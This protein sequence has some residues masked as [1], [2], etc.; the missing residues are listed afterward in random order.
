MTRQ[1]RAFMMTSVM[2]AAIIIACAAVDVDSGLHAKQKEDF[3]SLEK[4]AAL[5]LS[6]ENEFS[7]RAELATRLQ[8]GS[9]RAPDANQ[10]ARLALLWLR[11]QRSLL[12]MIPFERP[13]VSPYREWL[14]QHQDVVVY[15]EIGGQ[16]VVLPKVLWRVHDAYKSAEAAEAVAWFIVET[17]VPS[18]CEGHIPCYT[19][20]MNSVSGEFLRRHPRGLHASEAV[21][22]VHNS[23]VQAVESLSG[24]YAKDHL[25][26]AS[27]RD[28]ANLKQ[29]LQPLRQAI[30]NSN[31]D[32]RAAT[33][34]V[35]DSLLARC[36]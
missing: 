16:W 5:A 27:S 19:D 25:D 10:R 34:K 30:A 4:E 32:S 9:E 22:E 6:P 33:L 20:I 24:P 36:P 31:A 1:T 8:D 35:I 7:R 14:A 2:L 26:S 11:A 12:T 28:C 29:G 17:G 23:L 3:A 15:S 18:D 21:A 13:P